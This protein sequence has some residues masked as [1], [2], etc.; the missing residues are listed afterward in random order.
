MT[1]LNILKTDSRGRI[2][3]P[4]PFRNESLFEYTVEGDAITLYP[5]RTV[6][7]Y[8]DMDGL[9]EEDLSSD[10]SASEEEV[11]RDRRPGVSASTPS[12]A[13]KRIKR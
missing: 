10:W 2:T 3:L 9:P 13:L 6:R 1:D 11:N 4:A 12:E 5:V 8:P 7:K